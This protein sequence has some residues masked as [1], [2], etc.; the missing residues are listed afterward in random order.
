MI[1]TLTPNPSL[2]RT[3]ALDTLQRGGVHRALSLREDPGGKG[4]NVS[5][6]LAA[7][8]TATIAVLPAGGAMAAQFSSLLD[9]ARVPH[10]LIDLAGAVRT[11]ITLVE[12]DGTTTKINER[13]RLSTAADATLML[14]AV[15]A[16]LTGASWVVGCGSLPPGLDGSLYRELVERARARGVK[17]AIDTSGDALGDAIAARPDLVKP[18][19]H[20]L[21]EYVGHPLR[22]LSDVL[23]ASRDVV[24]SGVETVVVSLGSHGAVA[25]TADGAEH[26]VSRGTIPLSTVGAGDCLLAGWL[27]AVSAGADPRAAIAQ[28]VRWGSAAVELPGSSVPGP[29]DIAH[30]TVDTST[31][32]LPSLSMTSD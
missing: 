4:V 13:G 7:N 31:A 27:D 12:E 14:E 1:I 26:A 21:G 24:N 18:N 11:N 16:Q 25:V 28:A 20:E 5:R 15:E 30:V 17:I 19:H 22:Q 6:A 23:A 29:R 10:T 32:P 2:D 9:D 8:G 3:I